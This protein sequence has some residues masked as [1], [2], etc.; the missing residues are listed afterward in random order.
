MVY[1]GSVFEESLVSFPEYLDDVNFLFIQ[2]DAFNS[3]FYNTLAYVW[4][5]E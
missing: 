3:I 5:S 1:I 2:N 4:A